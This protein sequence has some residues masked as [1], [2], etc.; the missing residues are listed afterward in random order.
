MK[1]FKQ[2]ILGK[3]SDQEF[4]D[5]CD[6]LLIKLHL[7]RKDWETDDDQIQKLIDYNISI[8]V[9]DLAT[10]AAKRVNL[11]NQLVRLQNQIKELDE[12]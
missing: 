9:R 6:Q 8:G 11:Q 2:I 12:Y 10:L 7:L 5:R 1:L 4:I 3:H